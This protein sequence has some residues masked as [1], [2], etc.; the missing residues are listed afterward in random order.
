MN[1]RDEFH[2]Y[3]RQL[4]LY[5]ETEARERR[6]LANELVKRRLVPSSVSRDP[7]PLASAVS[8]LGLRGGWEQHMSDLKRS[9][10]GAGTKL[11]AETLAL[12]V[13]TEHDH[14]A[15]ERYFRLREAERKAKQAAQTQTQPAGRLVRK[16]FHQ[17][18]IPVPQ[19][20]ES[21]DEFLSRCIEDATAE[22]IDEDDATQ[23]C[24]LIWARRSAT[25]ARH[26]AAKDG[27]IWFTLSDESVDR[28]NDIVLQNWD[29]TQFKKNP[30][31]LFAHD[32][33]FPVGLWHDLEVR[34][35][36]LVGRLEL[37]PAGASERLDEIR[38]LVRAGILRSC[39]VGFQSLKSRPRKDANGAIIGMVFEENA[40]IEVSLTPTP[41]NPH[42][43]SLAK[44]LGITRGTMDI[45][46]KGGARR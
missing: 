40:L 29:L 23:E 42:A 10:P 38:A 12:F 36:A 9:Y 2:T 3:L 17:R 7:D 28:M 8:Y 31:C 18:T 11:L 14:E 33:R 41:A 30:V 44:Q 46:F 16:E 20:G 32:S 19:P 4:K 39:S 5:E 35:K 26:K 13:I 45:V 1:D 22:G 37:A 24:E 34:N 27:G 21:R 25:A 43:L 6:R 15:A